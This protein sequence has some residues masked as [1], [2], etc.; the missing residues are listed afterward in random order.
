MLAPG[1]SV[2]RARIPTRARPSAPTCGH[3]RAKGFASTCMGAPCQFPALPNP[4][5][6]QNHNSAE[7][8]CV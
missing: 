6:A 8:S 5:H 2:A 3:S 7:D 4:P 1:A